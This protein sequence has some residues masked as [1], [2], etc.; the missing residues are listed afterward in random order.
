MRDTY[1]ADFEKTDDGLSGTVIRYGDEAERHGAVH[2]VEPG[3]LRYS[4]VIVNLQHDRTKP[5]AR[6]GTD[7]LQLS[8]SDTQ[9][10]LSLT[11]PP[12][13][14]GNEARALVNAGLLSG[15]SMEIDISKDRWEGNRRYIEKADLWGVGIVD[16]PAFPQSRLYSED[17]QKTLTYSADLPLTTNYRKALVQGEY[18]WDTVGVVSVANRSAVRFKQGSLELAD[19]VVL[20]AGMNYDR[21]LASQVEGSLDLTIN[22]DGFYWS[23]KRFANT[24]E[25]QDTRKLLRRNLLTGFRLGIATRS[26]QISK[27]EMNGLEFTLETVTDG[28]VCEVGIMSTGTGSTGKISYERQW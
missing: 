10:D 9:F 4:D 7:F 26:S 21:I 19:N 24:T 28:I 11:Y 18:I 5:V 6:Q 27:T 1:Y 20:L 14:Y 3:A 25:G 17:L 23:A 22:K 12:T 15:L 2:I 13:P 16:R 8:D